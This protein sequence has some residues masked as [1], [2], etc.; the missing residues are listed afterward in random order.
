LGSHIDQPGTRL[1]QQQQQK[2]KAFLVR[3]H[4]RAGTDGVDGHGRHDHDGLRVLIEALNRFPQ[5]HQLLLELVEF[6]L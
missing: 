2:Q 4:Y 1:A 3:L 5:R 6:R